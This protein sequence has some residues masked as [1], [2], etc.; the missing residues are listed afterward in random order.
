[1]KGNYMPYKVGIIGFGYW[2]NILFKTII[3]L[4]EYDVRWIYD[5]KI[6]NNIE[7]NVQSKIEYYSDINE[8]INNSKEK[9]M[10]LIIIA[11]PPETHFDLAKKFMKKT[12][13]ILV[14]KPMAKNLKEVRELYREAENNGTSLLVDHTF[15]FHPA[16]RKIKEL[17][18]E[19]HI[20]DILHINSTRTNLGI[21]QEHANVAE[22]LQIHD[23]S[24]LQY[25][26][27]KAPA[28]VMSIGKT[29]FPSSEISTACTIIDYGEDLVVN[30]ISSWNSTVKVRNFTILGSRGCIIW[31]D[32]NKSEP[33]KLY[34][35]K[36][37]LSNPSDRE[38]R[39]ISY[40]LGNMKVFSLDGTPSLVQEFTE[41]SSNYSS[42]FENYVINKEH[43]L[44]T[45]YLI[46]LINESLNEENKWVLY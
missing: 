45:Y 44:A 27:E 43:V 28:K 19:N 17:I 15:I 16:V 40:F 39:N 25:L 23:I 1:M 42:R 14:E 10:D 6:K 29:H 31:D 11:T 4:P 36:V 18:K 37:E 21:I 34:N 7:N 22:D 9:M 24:I 35:S 20:G 12:K 2:G 13:T 30:L 46:D 41:I 33:L 26:L 8:L 32:T 3:N 38:G 5:L